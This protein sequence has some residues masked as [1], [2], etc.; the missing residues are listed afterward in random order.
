MLV[1]YEGND[2]K[3]SEIQSIIDRLLESDRLV[4]VNAEYARQLEL[5]EEELDRLI[6]EYSVESNQVVMK[7]EEF[8]D[9]EFNE[10]DMG[11]ILP[12]V[13]VKVD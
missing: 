5:K 10:D 6:D 12:T 11:P 1:E 9:A 8:I 4:K 3:I 2:V 7:N 13:S